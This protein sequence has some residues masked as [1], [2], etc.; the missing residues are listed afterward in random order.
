MRSKTNEVVF[1]FN[2]T[3]FDSVKLVSKMLNTI[4]AVNSCFDTFPGG[5]VRSRKALIIEQFSS[6][7]TEIAIWSWAWQKDYM[8]ACWVETNILLIPGKNLKMSILLAISLVKWML[9]LV[10]GFSNNILVLKILRIKHLQNIFNH[11]ASTSSV[12]EPSVPFLIYEYSNLLEQMITHPGTN[13]PTLCLRVIS[14][15]A[16]KVFITNIVY[17]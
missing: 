2:I 17:R 14:Y 5:G 10:S 8:S 6:I 16:K 11:F 15:Q 13:F 1:Y 7:L 9:I 12:V 4:S 3:E